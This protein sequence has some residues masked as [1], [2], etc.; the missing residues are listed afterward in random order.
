MIELLLVIG[1]I[2]S[3]MSIATVAYLK[4]K[5]N[6]EIQILKNHGDMIA[7]ELLNCMFYKESDKCLLGISYDGSTQNIQKL[8]LFK[9]LGFNKFKQPVINLKASWDSSS[10]KKN[11]CFQFNRRIQNDLYKLCVDVNRKTKV[12]RSVFI[13]KNFCC[14]ADSNSCLLPLLPKKAY[15]GSDISSSYCKK[16][17][18]L[19]SFSSYLSRSG[20][21]HAECK[22]GTCL[23]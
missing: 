16:N 19:D 18:Y 20:L 22:Q 15:I 11:F 13:N 23:Q 5:I 10:N 3:L 9:Q 7:K 2:V 14:K 17:G 1:L 6:S 8:D 4:H 21:S 12:I